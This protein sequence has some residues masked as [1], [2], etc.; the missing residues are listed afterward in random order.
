[1]PLL[2][3]CYYLIEQ[4]FKRLVLP[5]KTL[6]DSDRSSNANNAA[7]IACKSVKTRVDRMIL[8]KRDNIQNVKHN[9][10]HNVISIWSI[11]SPDCCFCDKLYIPIY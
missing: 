1:M 8:T 6:A 4:Y 9:P 2:G 10:N 5:K 7:N 11:S 3:Y